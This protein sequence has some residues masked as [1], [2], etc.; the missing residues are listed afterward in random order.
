MKRIFMAGLRPGHENDV[1]SDRRQ[2]RPS[3]CP[4]LITLLIDRGPTGD[5]ADR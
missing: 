4:A 2:R 5:A 1:T 3:P